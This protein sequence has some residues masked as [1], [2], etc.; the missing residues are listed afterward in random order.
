M[1][2]SKILLLNVG[3]TVTQVAV[4][5]DCTGLET[6]KTLPTRILNNPHAPCLPLFL[7]DKLAL[8]WFVACV[9]PGA[10]KMLQRVKTTGD[11][12]F[13]GPESAT[14]VDFSGIDT[15]SLGADRVANLSAAIELDMLPACIVDCGTCITLE[16]I[17]AGKRFRGGA[18][19][20]GRRMMRQALSEWTGQLPE[21]GDAGTLPKGLG[22][23]TEESIAL[24]VDGGVLAAVEDVQ[25]R[26][27]QQLSRPE[28][29]NCLATGGD[30][31]Y[32]TRH[33][34]GLTP[35][36]PAF[37]LTGLLHLARIA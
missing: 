17:D 31:E 15:S 18:I 16:L 12:F 1:A 10:K 8:P 13:I 14:D 24:G 32:F 27:L 26:A 9:V 35:A 5:S 36:P 20:P 7:E 19:L 3:N 11:L 28:D 23:N 30:Q 21:I 29:C 4:S 22:A 33:A 2:E 37:T 25:D 6:I 34:D